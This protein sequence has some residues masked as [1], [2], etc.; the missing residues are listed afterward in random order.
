[1]AAKQGFS[2]ETTQPTV[3]LSEPALQRAMRLAVD[4]AVAPIKALQEQMRTQQTKQDTMQEEVRQIQDAI[5]LSEHHL[6]SGRG[7]SAI[8]SPRNAPSLC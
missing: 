5:S 1:M 3:V 8:T 7:Q 2:V 4:A 6:V